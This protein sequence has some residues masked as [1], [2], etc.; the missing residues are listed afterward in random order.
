MNIITSI[1]L[2]V[3]SVC[4]LICVYSYYSS[5]F[6]NIDA[7]IL[8][9]KTELYQLSLIIDE[10]NKKRLDDKEEFVAFMQ[11]VLEKY[12]ELEKLLNKEYKPKKKQLLND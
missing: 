7:K 8:S 9:N 10:F 12:D 6:S 11:R 4:L 3:S 5:E 2:I 1:C